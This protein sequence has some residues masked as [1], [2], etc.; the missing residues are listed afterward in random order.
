MTR[1]RLSGRRR[2]LATV[3]F[4]TMTLQA[5]LVDVLARQEATPPPSPV[6]AT[7]DLA[8]LKGRIIADGSST[9]WPITD[10]VGILFQER[11]DGVR[12]EVD[13]SGTGGGFRK[14]CDGETDI[15]NASRPIEADE[16]AACAAAG[17]DYYAFR[18]AFDGITVV[19]N[20]TNDFA[21]CLTIEQLRSLWR[22]DRPARTWRDL[23]PAWPNRTIELYGPGPLS[24][25]FDYFTLAIVGTEG[26]SRTDYFPSEN[27]L[28]L[29]EGVEDRRQ[30]LGYFGF[31]YY[32][33]AGD[34]LSAVSI[35][36]GQGCVA[37][38][39]AT[40]ADGSYTP[41]SRPLYVYVK[42]DSLRRA[43]VQG[44]LRFY[45][46]SAGEIA[47]DVGYV[48]LPDDDYAA[49]RTKLEEAI[50]GALP[51]DAPSAGT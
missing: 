21:T 1:S 11:A 8:S 41:L 20:K 37:P 23:N 50:G 5:G 25:T 17:I 49:Q 29:V 2:W 30:G 3:V 35:D 39:V 7:P 9:V 46:A 19:V 6:A 48:P 27:D 24:G 33:D 15:Q 34:E 43:E 36:A 13:F 12:V 42:A 16:E 38:S 45:L 32:R 10:E 26:A 18:V 40:I 51:P 28:D 4:A 14:F 31:A 22:P 44:F 47:T